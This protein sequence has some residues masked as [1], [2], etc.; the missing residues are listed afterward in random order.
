MDV[1]FNTKK[2]GV[3]RSSQ[4]LSNYTQQ[5]FC[6]GRSG[7]EADLWLGKGRPP[8]ELL[9]ICMCVCVKKWKTACTIGTTSSPR[10]ISSALTRDDIWRIYGNANSLNISGPRAPACDSNNCSICI[11]QQCYILNIDSINLV[12]LRKILVS[13]QIKLQA[14]LLSA[15]MKFLFC[16]PKLLQ[17]WLWVI[18]KIIR[19]HWFFETWCIYNSL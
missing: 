11:Q 9:L 19:W 10:W 5:K 14:T 4:A 7:G 2:D 12:K 13:T 8:L 18:K 6:L 17:L 16:V 3:R 1:R 15:R